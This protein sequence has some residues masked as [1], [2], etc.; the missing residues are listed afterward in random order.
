MYQYLL[1][2][3]RRDI[4]L[5][6]WSKSI[7]LVPCSPTSITALPAAIPFSG[8]DG[9][10]TP[11]LNVGRV[12]GNNARSSQRINQPRLSQHLKSERYKQ[13]KALMLNVHITHHAGTTFCSKIGRLGP[14]PQFACMSG[15]NW[16]QNISNQIPWSHNATAGMVES[17]RKYF[18]MV[19][20]EFH[21]QHLETTNWEYVRIIPGSIAC[22]GCR[23]EIGLMCFYYTF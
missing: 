12:A 1:Q 3:N 19:S 9:T 7:A 8:H 13:G 14:A 4:E 18:H 17:L 20:W 15:D 21:L 10:K 22:A 6:E 11:V 5:Y 23:V 16:P 2:R